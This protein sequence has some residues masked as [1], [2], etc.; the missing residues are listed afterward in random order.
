MSV[1]TA[2]LIVLA[3]LALVSLGCGGEAPT[4]DELPPPWP[5]HC[6]RD[7]EVQTS[8]T[9]WCEVYADYETACCEYADGVCHCGVYDR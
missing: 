7:T 6:S 2:T 4:A 8:R 3:F 1:R 5:A 9:R